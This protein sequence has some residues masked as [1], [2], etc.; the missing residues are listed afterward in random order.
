MHAALRTPGHIWLKRHSHAVHRSRPASPPVALASLRLH[1]R[2]S[3]AAEEL[4]ALC[5]QSARQRDQNMRFKL[6]RSH[7]RA[8]QRARSHQHLH[9]HCEPACTHHALPNRSPSSAHH[10]EPFLYHHAPINLLFFARYGTPAMA[11]QSSGHGCPGRHSRASHQRRYGSCVRAPHLLQVHSKSFTV[12]NLPL[13]L[14]LLA[15][16]VHVTSRIAAQL[17][18]RG[19]TGRGGRQHV[20]I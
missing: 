11:L 12:A 16:Q 6:L 13:Q 15:W 8:L 18:A 19:C 7:A 9:R 17:G 20:L 3:P 4:R 14:P 10:L 1:A 2:A 5:H